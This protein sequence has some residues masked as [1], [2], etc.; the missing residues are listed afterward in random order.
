[1]SF[2]E[3]LNSWVSHSATPW[4]VFIVFVVAL[5]SSLY[6]LLRKSK[7]KSK[8][9]EEAIQVLKSNVDLKSASLEQE[10]TERFDLIDQQLTATNL[11]H[12]WAEFK[13]TLITPFEDISSPEFKLYQN[14]KRPNEYFNYHEI[15]SDVR[16]LISSNT[17]VGVGL[18]VTFT[19]LI[20]ALSATS[21]LFSSDG[22]D[23]LI[24][25]LQL[26]LAT[27]GAKFVASV[28]GL[29]ASLI[30]ESIFSRRKSKNAALLSEFTQFLEKCLVH[31]STE[32]LTA[33]QLAHSIRQTREL[34]SLAD[35][36]AVKI[37][38]SVSEAIKTIPIALSDELNKTFEPVVTSI[39][40]TTSRM[41]E[42]NQDALSEMAK[43][44]AEQISGAS[45]EAMDNVVSQLNSLVGSLEIASSKLTDGSSQI[46]ESFGSAFNDL[47]SIMQTMHSQLDD[48]VEKVSQKFNANS[49]MLSEQMDSFLQMSKQTETD[50]QLLIN[51]LSESVTSSAAQ[52]SQNMSDTFS[53]TSRSVQNAISASVD[54]VNQQ[55]NETTNSLQRNLESSSKL[56][57]KSIEKVLSN[58]DSQ[59]L[60]VMQ[61]VQ[62][63]LEDQSIKIAS[64]ISHSMQ[65]VTQHVAKAMDESNTVL[66]MAFKNLNEV[67]E[68]TAGILKDAGTL[69][70]EKA[71]L[72]STSLDNV[73]RSLNSVNSSLKDSNDAVVSSNIVLKNAVT[74]LSNASKESELGLSRMTGAIK[75]ISELQSSLLLCA[76]DMSKMQQSGIKEAS[77]AI[78][79]LERL[80]SLSANRLE[81]LDVE[82]ERAFERLVEGLT[83]NMDKIAEFSQKVDSNTSES[84]R[85]LGSMV[86]D[87]TDSINELN[88]KKRHL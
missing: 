18:L 29:G 66:S 27:A 85:L 50:T 77:E 47:K 34:E 5:I 59:M 87:L 44:F 45:N 19:G 68:Q 24:T 21:Q 39:V 11:N 13:E 83:S 67:I 23:D 60:S 32:S 14:T 33:R 9:L 62:S 6:V 46:N 53:H 30:Q 56:V 2:L 37:G 81:G 35:S 70:A 41:G 80:W 42:S 51:S 76:E 20:I 75:T 7:V 63:S 43:N 69:W 88:S 72:T 10:F 16:P 64:D 17:F 25:G 82:M 58:V 26:L 71:G 54:A 15:F 49:L 38:N 12:Q 79:S 48:S 1:M 28:S 61:K 57:D 78:K 84:I 74:S 40:E 22:N 3:L 73:D 36:I 52:I 31:S 65:D 86:E 8:T 4:I 55:L